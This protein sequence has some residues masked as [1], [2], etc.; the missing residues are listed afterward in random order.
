MYLD[1]LGYLE[2][3]TWARSRSEPQTPCRAARAPLGSP[4][5]NCTCA[6]VER[7][8][9]GAPSRGQ[10]VLW[11][12]GSTGRCLGLTLI[13]VDLFPSSL[14]RSRPLVIP[15]LFFLLAARFAA[16]P[17]QPPDI[18]TTIVCP[19]D[20]RIRPNLFARLML[21]P[22][23]CSHQQFRPSC[24]PRTPVAPGAFALLLC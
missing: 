14:L 16:S 6:Q 13:T 1:Q 15:S 11:V 2:T 23:D 9:S 12:T 19:P 8:P 18:K 24:T 3:G 7:P 10:Y 17:P 5:Y 22:C 21:I 20:D 4:E